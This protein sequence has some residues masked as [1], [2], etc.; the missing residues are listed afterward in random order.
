MKDEYGGKTILKF[1]CLKSKMYSLLDESNNEKSTS[2]R[3]N[4]FI[5]SR[6]SQYTIS[7]KDS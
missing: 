7:E 2:K 3:H 4:S 6:I 1:V 5:V